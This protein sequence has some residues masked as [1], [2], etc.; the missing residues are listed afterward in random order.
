MSIGTPLVRGTKR[1]FDLVALPVVVRIE[2][3]EAFSR[4]HQPIIRHCTA[5]GKGVAQAIA[6]TGTAPH[7]EKRLTGTTP[8][9]KE[10][11]Y[12]AHV[13]LLDGATT[14]RKMKLLEF[15]EGTMAGQNAQTAKAVA[16]TKEAFAAGRMVATK[17]V[18]Q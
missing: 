6:V 7:A 5:F 15:G 1:K 8:L 9:P 16:A 4:R 10:E 13:V 17:S 14:P 11:H 18:G 3:G 2:G 12:D